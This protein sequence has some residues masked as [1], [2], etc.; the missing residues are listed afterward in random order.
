MKAI[1]KR[2]L[3]IRMFLVVLM[4]GVL[5][6]CPEA[7]S[8]EPP[9]LALNPSSINFTADQGVKRELEIT[10]SSDA[11]WFVIDNGWSDWLSLSTTSGKGNA[12]ISLTTKNVNMGNS[13][14]MAMEVMAQNEGGVARQKVEL[15]RETRIVEDQKPEEDKYTLTVSPSSMTFPSAGGQQTA[16]IMS[17][18]IWAIYSDQLWCTVSKSNGSNNATITVT[19]DKNTTNSSRTAFV[20]IVGNYSGTKSINII[21]GGDD[22]EEVTIADFNSRT[23]GDALYK[24]TGVITRI[25]NTTYGNIYIKD[26]TDETYI[27]GTLTA[28]GQSQQ[29]ASLGLKVGDIVTL[30]GPK[31]TYGSTVE[32]VNGLYQG[33]IAVTEVSIADFLNKE[34]NPDIYY[35]VTGTITEIVNAA[36]GNLYLSDGTNSLYVY[37][38]YPGWGATGDARKDCIATL[39]IEVG[40]RLTVIGTKFTY[41]GM[42]EV[43]DGI[44]FSHQKSD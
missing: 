38:C 5:T 16:A 20:N 37:G 8:V 14:S 18:D 42:V 17:N 41:N 33:H 7:D 35:R 3:L 28:D 1:K 21:Q 26:A 24:I 13:I 39:G 12:N 25:A 29:F 19:V 22:I 4:S 23:D 2:M 10:T 6:A 44:Y 30:V 31:T 43:K 11:T 34:D 32:M 15:I 9:T 27:Y 40:D 36:Y